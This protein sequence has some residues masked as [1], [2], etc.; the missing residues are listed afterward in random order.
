MQRADRYGQVGLQQSPSH[1]DPVTI[2]NANMG[3]LP[4]AETVGL[5][6]P[7]T[8]P[9]ASWLAK[10]R[11]GL[12]GTCTL[13]SLLPALFL[14]LPLS[15]SVLPL[16]L[17]LLLLLLPGGVGSVAASHTESITSLIC[18]RSQNMPD[19]SVG[20]MPLQHKCTTNCK[21]HGFQMSNSM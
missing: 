14:L 10:I 19:I 5:S 4:G 6:N 18:E 12:N 2:K 16:R 20:S 17:L 13:L 9:Y 3:R 1:C 7:H 15:P 21:R 11:S 8:C